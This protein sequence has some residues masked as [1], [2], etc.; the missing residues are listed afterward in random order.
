MKLFVELFY[1]KIVIVKKK[2]KKYYI[3]ISVRELIY[4][5]LKILII[6]YVLK[7]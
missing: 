1:C 3:V 6:K 5:V 2:C 4:N 7:N